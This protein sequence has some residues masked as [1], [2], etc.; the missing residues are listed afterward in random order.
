MYSE[1]VVVLSIPLAIMQLKLFG[2]NMNKLAGFRTT[3][4]TFTPL[5][6]PALQ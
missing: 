5:Q 2:L 6:Y 4:V 1:M 3:D